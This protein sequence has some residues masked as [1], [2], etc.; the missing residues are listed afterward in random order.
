[1][2]LQLLLLAGCDEGAGENRQENCCAGE[3]GH[4]SP[5]LNAFDIL[6]RQSHRRPAKAG[7][8]NVNTLGGGEVRARLAG[9]LA[10]FLLSSP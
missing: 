3:A 6:P 5:F 2:L 10:G 9:A 7:R 4:Y 8:C 1:L